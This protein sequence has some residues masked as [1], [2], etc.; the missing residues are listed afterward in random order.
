MGTPVRLHEG[1]QLRHEL[2]GLVLLRMGSFK[3]RQLR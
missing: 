2:H 3:R 1:Q